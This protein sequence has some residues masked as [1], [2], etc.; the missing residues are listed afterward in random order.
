MAVIS[1]GGS[2]S[3]EV[4]TADGTFRSR[5]PQV[6]T[7]DGDKNL[8][9][10][11]PQDTGSTADIRFMF[12][13]TNVP[14]GFTFGIKQFVSIDSYTILHRGM[15]PQDGTIQQI[16][17]PPQ[18]H[19]LDV[20]ATSL[21]VLF[22]Q[23]NLPTGARAS[24]PHAPFYS[25]DPVRVRNGQLEVLTI[26]DSPGGSFPLQLQ[27]M[28]TDR[29]TYLDEIGI[30]QTFLTVLVAVRPDA[31]HVP[32][33]GLK[34]QN[35]VAGKLTWTKAPSPA[36]DVNAIAHVNTRMGVFPRIGP[37]F[38]PMDFSLIKDNALS[39]GDSVVQKMNDAMF[40]V[41]GRY[42]SQNFAK[43]ANAEV[44]LDANGYSLVQRP[45]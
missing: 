32:L 39:A 2:A 44:R 23:N 41:R 37:D 20:A 12:R 10:T 43:P 15:K 14:P 26:A 29:P 18:R 28:A 24:A 21:T 1:L 17:R 35:S 25:N 22:D 45:G 42:R 33:V 34:W 7:I 13:T 3:V 11:K 30:R 27:N 16:Y 36:P 9:F 6:E 5:A 38:L 8:T 40:A 4:V 19:M 31:T